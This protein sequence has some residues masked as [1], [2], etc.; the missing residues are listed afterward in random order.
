MV[1]GSQSEELDS[2]RSNNGV[3]DNELEMKAR[4]PSQEWI[5]DS[6]LMFNLNQKSLQLLGRSQYSLCDLTKKPRRLT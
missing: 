4:V 3:S 5:V 6:N 1:E 2:E